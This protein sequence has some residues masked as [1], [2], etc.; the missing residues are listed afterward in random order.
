MKSYESQTFG[1]KQPRPKCPSEYFSL[2][3]EN[4]CAHENAVSRT[5]LG[6]ATFTARNIYSTTTVL[7][8]ACRFEQKLHVVVPW[9]F[10]TTIKIH[11]FERGAKIYRPVEMC[12]TCSSVQQGCSRHSG[13]AFH[14]FQG[15]NVFQSLQFRIYVALRIFWLINNKITKEILP[16][17]TLG[18]SRCWGKFVMRGKLV[19]N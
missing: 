4:T 18:C 12:S 9:F 2:T 6:Q 13:H 11:V 19:E 14:L 1:F 17:E 10:P 3:I 7:S 16:T 8:T 5:T 15:T